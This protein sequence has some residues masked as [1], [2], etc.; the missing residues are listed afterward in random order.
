MPVT[1]LRDILN[2]SLKA[3]YGVPAINL[4]NDLTLDGGARGGC[5]RPLSCHRPDVGQDR[6]KHRH[7]RLLSLVASHDQ[8]HRGSGRTSSRTTAR[9][10]P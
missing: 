4:V 9:T 8:G 5:R 7:R 2:P 3:G 6:P 10:E 1:P